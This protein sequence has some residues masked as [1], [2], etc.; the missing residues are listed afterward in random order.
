MPIRAPQIGVA[1][2]LFEIM[3][4]VNEALPEHGKGVISPQEMA[5]TGTANCFGRLAVIG[6]ELVAEGFASEDVSLL[7][8]MNHGQKSNNGKY[9][10]GHAFLA[11]SGPKPQLVDSMSQAYTRRLATTT[12]I[13][14]GTQTL[15]IIDKT[16]LKEVQRPDLPLRA[17]KKPERSIELARN[18]ALRAFFS[19]HS[20]DEGIS[21]YQET[22]PRLRK[23]EHQ[24]AR[25][26]S[27]FYAS[28][29]DYKAAA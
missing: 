28:F 24:K 13:P 14:N 27:S 2:N 18:W 25:D 1:H 8:S 12:W 3:T 7:I 29:I 10:F 16:V 20:F 22:H 11:I 15:P 17:G 9:W 26:Y 5:A 4:T 6:S 23:L 19:H 21:Y